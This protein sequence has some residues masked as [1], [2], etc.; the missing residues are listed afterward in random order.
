MRRRRQW[1]LWWLETLGDVVTLLV[2]CC[3]QMSD[4]FGWEGRRE[5]VI[6]ELTRKTRRRRE[7]GERRK[8]L[9]AGCEVD[10]WAVSRRCRDVTMRRDRGWALSC[11]QC[12]LNC[13]AY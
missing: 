10:W 6:S 12:T 3:W 7:E 11:E 13:T 2:L 5:E 9:G 1:W 4:W 8:A